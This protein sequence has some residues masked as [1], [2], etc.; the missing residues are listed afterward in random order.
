LATALVTNN[1]DANTHSLLERFGLNF[2]VVLT[3]DSGL[4]KP[5][6]APIR[7]VMKRLG[8]APRHC[9][10][11]GDSRYDVDAAHHAGCGR[12]CVLYGAAVS[13]RD[14]ADLAFRDLEAFIRYLRVVL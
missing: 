1:T 2:D 14:R 11:V 9:L 12:V 5:S 8:K 13:H 10:A 7:E 6:G 3:R 4:W